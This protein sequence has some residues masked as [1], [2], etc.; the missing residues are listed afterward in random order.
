MNQTQNC[1]ANHF[2]MHDNQFADERTA[3]DAAVDFKRP[4]LRS[5]VAHNLD[6]ESW[7]FYIFRMLPFIT[8]TWSVMTTRC[9][10]SARSGSQGIGRISDHLSYGYNVHAPEPMA[11]SMSPRSS[12]VLCNPTVADGQRKRLRQLDISVLPLTGVLIE[13]WFDCLLRPNINPFEQRQN[14]CLRR[15]KIDLGNLLILTC[16]QVVNF[17]NKEC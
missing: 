10:K 5:T 6:M 14:R 16:W 4:S 11:S 15:L 9:R 7:I 2:R 13:H 8:R 1:C 3:F 12:K 17:E